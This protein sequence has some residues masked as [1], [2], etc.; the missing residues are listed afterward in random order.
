MR[1]DTSELFP[2]DGKT[3]SLKSLAEKYLDKENFQVKNNLKINENHFLSFLFTSQE[4]EHDSIEDAKATMELYNMFEKQMEDIASKKDIDEIEIPSKSGIGNIFGEGGKNIRE[5]KRLSGAKIRIDKGKL[6]V[7]ILGINSHSLSKAKELINKV[8]SDP[9]SLS[10]MKNLPSY[11]HSKVQLIATWSLLGICKKGSNDDSSSREVIFN[12]QNLEKTQ[13]LGNIISKRKENIEKIQTSSGAAVQ[14]NISLAFVI[15]GTNSE[16]VSKA[17]HLVDKIISIQKSSKKET[18]RNVLQN[19]LSLFDN[20]SS[21][22]LENRF[23]INGLNKEMFEVDVPKHLIK[24]IVEEK[25]RKC[26]FEK[27]R[28]IS[29]DLDMQLKKSCIIEILGNDSES[30]LKAKEIILNPIESF[31]MLTKKQI[32]RLRRKRATKEMADN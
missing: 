7:E 1:R 17:K 29:D 11:K 9:D 18:V 8:V 22:I 32:K 10:E 5:I 26:I 20:F 28:E 31:E 21:E 12:D 23:D 6:T 24:L 16:S 27:I 19:T 2:I 30:V 15:S 4:G 14:T 3:P 25:N 13:V